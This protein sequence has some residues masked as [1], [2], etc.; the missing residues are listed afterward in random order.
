MGGVSFAFASLLPLVFL[1]MTLPLVYANSVWSY[2]SG[3]A[4]VM[5][6]GSGKRVGSCDQ[7]VGL[8]GAHLWGAC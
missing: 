7:G 1:S 2:F 5:E 6:G 4:V 3:R 8:W